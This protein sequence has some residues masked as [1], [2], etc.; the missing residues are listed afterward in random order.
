MVLLVEAVLVVGKGL[1]LTRIRGRRGPV[2]GRSVHAALAL[3]M[4]G[5]TALIG[6]RGLRRLHGASGLHGGRPA[7]DKA[8]RKQLLSVTD[9]KFKYDIL[10][11]SHNCQTKQTVSLS[12]GFSLL[13]W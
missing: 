9:L 12:R 8:V 5:D 6:K 7:S 2:A 4:T 3:M 1:L 13:Y 10:G 11:D